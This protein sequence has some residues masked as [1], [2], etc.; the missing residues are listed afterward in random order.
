MIASW[1]E[2][3]CRGREAANNRG[4]RESVLEGNVETTV[5]VRAVTSVFPRESV[6]GREGINGHVWRER[7]WGGS[8][9]P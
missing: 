1:R 2:N 6:L 7:R 9:L 3:Q 8:G 4:K 5:S